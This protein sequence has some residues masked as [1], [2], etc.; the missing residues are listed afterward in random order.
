M[1][2]KH[3]P[4]LTSV[5]ANETN[6]AG[7]SGGNRT[8][9]GFLSTGLRMMDQWPAMDSVRHRLLGC[10]AQMLRAISPP[11]S[12]VASAASANDITGFMEVHDYLEH[13]PISPQEFLILMQVYNQSNKHFNKISLLDAG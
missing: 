2:Q 10:I 6:E 7:E 3:K 12:V 4:L 13:D 5:D 9:A 1:Q 8:E 11:P